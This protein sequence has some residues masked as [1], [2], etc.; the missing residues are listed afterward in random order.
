M[1]RLKNVSLTIPCVVGSYTSINCTLTLLSS[2]TRTKSISDSKYGQPDEDE[3]HF[4]TNFAAMQSIATSTA[5]NDSGLFEVNF[6]DE[7]YLPFEGAGAVSCWRIDLPKDCNAFDFD[8]ISDV[9]LKLSYTAREG[10]NSLKAAA[11]TAM[12]NALKVTDK[13][14]LARLFSAK[15]EFP[16]GWHRFLNPTDPKN[17]QPLILDFSKERFPFQFRSKKL[18]ISNVEFFLDLKDEIKPGTQPPKTYTQAYASGTPLNIT[19]RSPDNG[20]TGGS[21]PLNS[22]LSS[23]SGIPHQSIEKLDIEVKSGNDALWSLLANA[24]PLKDAIADLFILCHYSV[25]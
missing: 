5:Q 1:R 21:K 20:D 4:I 3:G 10:G 9:I 22:N 7:R 6:R 13:A 2:K 18:T 24:V 23:L 25:G 12:E 11:K 14:P 16:T 15:H 19:L 17:P 8:T